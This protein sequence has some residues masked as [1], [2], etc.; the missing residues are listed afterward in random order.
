MLQM[1]NKPVSDSIHNAQMNKIV[2]VRGVAAAPMIHPLET[3]LNMLSE[4]CK[5]LAVVTNELLVER[6]EQPVLMTPAEDAAR[7]QAVAGNGGKPA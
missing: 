3:C 2:N 4:I 5:T 7:K 1:S 6:G